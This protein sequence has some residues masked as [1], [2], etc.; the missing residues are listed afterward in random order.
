M[1]H[2]MTDRR[3]YSWEIDGYRSFLN[4][5]TPETAIADAFAAHPDATAVTIHA[6]PANHDT[7]PKACE[8]I[9]CPS[10]EDATLELDAG[11]PNP[12][13][14]AVSV[15]HTMTRTE[16][17]TDVDPRHVMILPRGAGQLDVPCYPHTPAEAAAYA[18]MGAR[19]VYGGEL[20]D[21]EK[22]TAWILYEAGHTDL[23]VVTP[24]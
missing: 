2:P 24:R 6:T 20:G 13:L 19:F 14:F 9:P 4:W 15:Y 10:F 21:F 11:R 22:D 18:V 17:P 7:A 5:S 1:S 23:V 3:H 8:P 16:P 12:G